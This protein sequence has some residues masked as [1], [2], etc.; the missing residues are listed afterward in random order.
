MRPDLGKLEEWADLA[1][2]WASDV[3]QAN[4]PDQGMNEARVEALLVIDD[5]L[6]IRSASKLQAVVRFYHERMSMAVRQI[7]VKT[8]S[9]TKL[10][11]MYN[12]GFVI[13]TK[14]ATLALDLVRGC[15]ATTMRDDLAERLARQIDV[16]TVSHWHGDHADLDLC[17]MI[18]RS[19]AEILVPPDLHKRWSDEPDLNLIEMHP[20]ESRESRMLSFSALEGHHDGP[21][22]RCDLNIYY[23]VTPGGLSIMHMGDHWINRRMPLLA[24]EE[25]VLNEWGQE[26]PVDVLLL[27]RSPY[28]F[29]NIIERIGPR[30]TVSSHENELSHDIAARATYASSIGQMASV[31]SPCL[32]I[33]WGEGLQIQPFL[34]TA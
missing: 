29:S 10:W 7:E 30:L 8:R 14:E 26:Y 25:N 24:E 9:R 1:L 27:N 19:G 28:Q 13:R 4:P 15:G 5:V 12:H 2:D 18:C 33:A 6:H 17:K 16:A 20:G 21:P 34:P 11:K 22:D 3:L 31:G 23:I 32:T